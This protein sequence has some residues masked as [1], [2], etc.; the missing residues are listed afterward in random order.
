VEVRNNKILIDGY[1]NAVERES[2][3]LYDT[4]G[5][6]IEKI[7]AGVFQRA[8]EK[9]ENV[10][11]LL[12]HEPDREL[13]DTKSGKARL[14]EDNIG[15]RATV[16]IDDPEVIQKAKENKLRGWSFGFLCNKEDRTT[17]EDGIEKRTVR[18]LDLLEVSIIDDRKSPAYL[19]TSI[20]V[21]D[22]KVTLIEYRTDMSDVDV[23]VIEDAKKIDYSE[24]ENRLAK[25]KES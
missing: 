5:Q 11:V 14:V 8:L 21:R 1:V 22:D 13:A 9:A 24:Y 16:E 19:G 3:V 7:R 23:R 20:E 18:D 25:V 17:D 4:R 10:R 12:D 2:K 15:L 6:F